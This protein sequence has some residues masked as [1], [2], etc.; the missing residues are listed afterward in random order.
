MVAGGQWAADRLPGLEVVPDHGGGARTGY[1][2]FKD[3]GHFD[4]VTFPKDGDGC[5]WDSTPH[6]AQA[7]VRLQ[8]IGH[9]RVHRHRPVRGRVETIG[10][11]REGRCWY[12][13]RDHDVIAH[14]RLNTTGMTR[15]PEPKPDPERPGSF[16][17]S[18]AAAK[19]GLNR[20][21]L[22][23]GWGPREPRPQG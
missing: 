17:P 13:V 20:G 5:R 7:R 9:A 12:L 6:D 3:V 23:T 18:G 19:A 16:L 14:E 1:P 8:G 21:T 2:G 10:I 11:K 22:D 4:T 15:A